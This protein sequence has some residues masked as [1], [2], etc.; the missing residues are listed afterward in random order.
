[1]GSEPPPTVWRTPADFDAIDAA[2]LDY[3]TAQTHRPRR[4][5]WSERRARSGRRTQPPLRLAA[6]AA[7]AE[8]AEL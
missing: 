8:R 5:A 2:C 1:M 7:P 4:Q 3:S 6:P